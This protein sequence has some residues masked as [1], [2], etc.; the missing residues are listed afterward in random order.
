MTNIRINEIKRTIEVSGKGFAKKAS[1]Y[2][3]EEYEMLQNVRKDYPVFK[4]ITVSAEKKKASY[5]GLT[6]E[7][8]EMYIEKHDDENKSKMAA[9]KTLRAIDDEAEAALA[10]SCSY[11]KI[12]EWFL[13]EFKEI[14]EF[15]K[16]RD[17]ILSSK[18]SA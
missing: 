16:K 1:T 15:H 14:A 13:R 6:Y 18:K 8:M 10:E 3:T 4:V 11:Q 12:K 9:Y 7:Y 2:G 17:E 5:K